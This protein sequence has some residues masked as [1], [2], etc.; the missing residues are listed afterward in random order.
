MGRMKTHLASV[1]WEKWVTLS[2]IPFLTYQASYP[3]EENII[4]EI[5]F[6]EDNTPSFDP[7]FLF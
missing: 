4:S 3:V 6:L 2:C 7:A 5:L 1:A